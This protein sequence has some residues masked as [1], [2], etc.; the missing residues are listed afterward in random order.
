MDTYNGSER[1]WC[2]MMSLI[3]LAVHSSNVKIQIQVLTY[4]KFNKDKRKRNFETKVTEHL[5]WTKQFDLNGVRLRG[6]RN[7]RTEN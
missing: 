1:V 6:E 5:S 3:A 7:T 4:V 2:K